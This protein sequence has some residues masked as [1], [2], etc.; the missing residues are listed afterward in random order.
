MAQIRAGRYEDALRS[1]T[2]ALDLNPVGPAW[3]H[4]YK[5]QALYALERAR[6]AVEPADACAVRAA[7]W[8]FCYVIKAAALS[9][10][11]DESGAKVSVASLLALNPRY[12]LATAGRLTPFP[13]DPAA[14]A[15]YVADLRRA[16]LPG[17]AVAVDR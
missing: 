17:D 1:I 9:A 5:A 11:G 3:Y 10:L 7:R 16:G 12:D 15:R 13:G 2:E 8:V 6:E 4:V 14:T